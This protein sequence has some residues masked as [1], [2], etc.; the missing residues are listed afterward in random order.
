MGRLM[1]WENAHQSMERNSTG[2]GWRQFE[3]WIT[4]LDESGRL[5]TEP[6][7][8][9]SSYIQ[10][11]ADLGQPGIYLWLLILFCTF[12]SVAFYKARDEIQE[13]CRRAVLLILIAYMISS[14]M[15]NREYHT[16]YYLI[17]AIGAA[18]HRLVIANSIRP[19]SEAGAKDED[20][21]VPKSFEWTL[22]AYEQ[23]AWLNPSEAPTTV[24]RKLWMSLDW[25]DL[26]AAAAGTWMV[27]Y[28][29]EYV[30]RNL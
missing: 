21:A 1:A 28:I 19:V 26:L 25:K 11:G 16:E 15:I 8:T 14:W 20:D 24:T 7:S 30:L 29:W 12:R 9:H 2:A 22:P 3:A 10:I 18:F 6:K 13:R 4:F 17:A 5:I 23:A 27:L